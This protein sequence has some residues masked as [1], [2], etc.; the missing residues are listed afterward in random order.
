MDKSKKHSANFLIISFII[1]IIISI[2]SM[3]V[4]SF[5]LSNKSESVITELGNLYMQGISEEISMHFGTTIDFMLKQ[6]ETITKNDYVSKLEYKDQ[7]NETLEYEGKVRDIKCMALLSDSSEIEMIYGEQIH[8]ADP[9][10]FMKSM[11]AKE[12]KVAIK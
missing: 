3:G 6:L 4:F 7:L 12:K 1:I 2:I 9:D 11:R 10:P 5:A 8:F